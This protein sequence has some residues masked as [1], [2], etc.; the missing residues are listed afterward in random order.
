MPAHHGDQRQR[1]WSA[2]THT[3]RTRRSCVR[4]TVWMEPCTRR[5]RTHGDPAVADQLA[6]F[7]AVR[8]GQ[9]H[10]GG[11][12]TAPEPA[13]ALAPHHRPRGE[14][15][16]TLLVRGR[17]GASLTE[18]GRRLLDLVEAR[19]ALEEELLGR[20]KS[21]V[22]VELSGRVR[23]T[24][25]SS[26]L[27]PV[28]LPALAPFLRAHPAVQIEIQRD[29]DRRGVEA[30]VAGRVDFAL[31]QAPSDTPGIVDLQLGDEEFVMVESRV[32]ATR[33]DVFLDVSPRDN[34]TE[35]FFASQPARLRPRGRWSARSCTTSPA[36]CSASSRASAAR[37]SRAARCARPGCASMAAS[38]RHQAGLPAP[39]AAA[40]LRPLAHAIG[41]RIAT[42]VREHLAR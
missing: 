17:T 35:V 28:V 36:S 3:V 16:T 22:G 39:P 20:A 26:L 18:A 13:G 21:L 42:A 9:L 11:D 8:R 19:Q 34:T 23:L 31:A 14:L 33:R 4:R 27:P 32:H 12:V 1:E 7:A 15:E 41:T 10:A 5:K 38:S 29:V 25:L 6:A 37:S 2:H 30:L 40:L 24:G